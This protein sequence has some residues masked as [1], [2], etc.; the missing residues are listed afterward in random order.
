MAD[1]REGETDVPLPARGRDSVFAL[2]KGGR[3]PSWHLLSEV[4]RTAAEQHHINLMLSVAE[5]HGMRRLEGF[6]LLGRQRDWERFWVIEFPTVEGAEAW[7]EAEMAPPYG[8]HGFYEYHLARSWAV[9]HLK[10]WPTFPR[11]APPGLTADPHV[12][13]VLGADPSS[14]VVLL[15]GRG[16]PG[17]QAVSPEARGDPEHVELMQRVAAEHRMIRI[18]AFQLMD[19]LA[20]WHRAWVIEF[21]TLEGAEAWMTN[22]VL[23]PHGAYSS[24]AFLLARRWSPEYFATWVP[25]LVRE[26]A[27]S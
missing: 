7:I 6:R 24:K 5:R 26:A 17:Y 1:R 19:P 14:I 25:R 22:E 20:D 12:R 2:F 16:R 11:P 9:E 8:L 23:P 21:P 10:T 13:P 15:F 18:E 27:R 4:E 3:L